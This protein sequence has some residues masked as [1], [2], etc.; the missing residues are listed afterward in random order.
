MMP[1]HQ[2]LAMLLPFVTPALLTARTHVDAR[3]VSQELT[4][5]RISM[6]VLKVRLFC[7]V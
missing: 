1:V 7:C 4:A 2:T 3:Q 5:M 6:N